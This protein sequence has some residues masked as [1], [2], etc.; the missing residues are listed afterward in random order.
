MIA[1]IVSVIGIGLY[2]LLRKRKGA[3]EFIDGDRAGE[4][5]PLDKP[6]IKIGALVDENDLVVGDYKGKVSRFHCEI[7]REG[8]RYFIKD[9]STNGTLV[10]EKYIEPG[11]PKA[12][13]KG[14]RLSLAGEVTLVFRLI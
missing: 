11:Q 1:A 14:D 5:F 10:N 13:R 6:A 9:V 2:F 7:I 8:R 4:I 3:F 12:L